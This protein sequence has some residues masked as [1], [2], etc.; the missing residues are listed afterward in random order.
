MQTK[1][2]FAGET[3]KRKTQSF[4]IVSGGNKGD[5]WFLSYFFSFSKI[6]KISMYYFYN[7]KKKH[8]YRF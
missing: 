1:Q 5:F 4:S 3:F 8:D 6:K 7:E 2:S